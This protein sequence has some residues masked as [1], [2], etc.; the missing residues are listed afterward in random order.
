MSEAVIDTL[1]LAILGAVLVGSGLYW[2]KDRLMG[3]S[4]SKPAFGK[5]PLVPMQKPN[6]PALKI[7]K[8]VRKTRDFVQKMKE[9]VSCAA[10][11]FIP[12]SL[13]STFF[14]HL[15]LLQLIS[16]SLCL[17]LTRKVQAQWIP[18]RTCSSNTHEMERS[19]VRYHFS[20][21]VFSSTTLCAFRPRILSSLSPLGQLSL[22][23][24]SP[25]A[26]GRKKGLASI[27]DM[28]I[29]VEMFPSRHF[30]CF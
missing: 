7:N 6:A 18:N 16:L 25:E 3:S 27:L 20:I 24:D 23:V 2:F 15:F 22:D 9:T 5:Q 29:R 8:V 19:G 1:D 17:A 11:E 12:P 13:V 28:R 4:S 10:F 21:L 14:F 30:N 26:G